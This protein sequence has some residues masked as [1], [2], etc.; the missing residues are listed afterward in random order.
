MTMQTTPPG[1]AKA[2]PH[3]GMVHPLAGS[4]DEL[5][6]AG[7]RA[8][9]MSDNARRRPRF[10]HLAQMFNLG[11]PVPGETAEVGCFR[12]LSSFLLCHLERQAAPGFTGA[13]HSVVDSFE[14][15]GP[16]SAED[17]L[18]PEVEGRF[19]TT[20]VEHVRRTLAEFPGVRIYKGW[21]PAAFIMLPE[22][23]YRFVH[24]D[25]DLYKPTRDS[26]EYFYPRLHRGGMIVV[27]DFGPWPG[28]G[29]YPGCAR[30]VMEFCEH[31]RLTF[32]ALTTG[33][34]VITRQR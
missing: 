26:L 27:D 17:E 1:S 10:Y 30:A 25:V 13:T 33:N 29:K 12:G 20:S 21:V 23:R 22:R 4:F 6:D 24:V 3:A 18:P 2:A 8:A 11:R 31:W 16:P 34:A 14:G 15:L 19:S 7:L 32:A 28:G 9:G 5:Y